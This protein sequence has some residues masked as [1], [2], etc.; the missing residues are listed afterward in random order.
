V[1][2]E[3]LLDWSNLEKEI[4]CYNTLLKERKREGEK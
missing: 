1:G 4:A 3:G 2:G